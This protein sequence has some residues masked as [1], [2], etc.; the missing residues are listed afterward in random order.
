MTDVEKPGA[1][2]SEDLNSSDDYV[3]EKARSRRSS[4]AGGR[5]ESLNDLDDPDAGK[6]DEERAKIVRLFTCIPRM[7]ANNLQDKKL[8]RRIDLW[9]IPWLCL[10]YLLSFLGELIIHP[11]SFFARD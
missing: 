6:S 4:V 9:L 3:N 7:S 10:L 5:A 2:H 11:A 8:V 1:L